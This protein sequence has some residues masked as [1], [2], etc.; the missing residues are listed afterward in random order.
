MA[1]LT[2]AEAHAKLKKEYDA[3][4]ADQLQYII[5]PMD[6]ALR[7]IELCEEKRSEQDCKTDGLHN[8]LNKP[9]G[10]Y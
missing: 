8:I 10:T 6:V 1:Q 4:V 5:L 2:Y 9:E 7:L 3:S